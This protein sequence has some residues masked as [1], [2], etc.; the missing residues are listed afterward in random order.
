MFAQCPWSQT[1]V[2]VEKKIDLKTN[3]AKTLP[4]QFF[5]QVL[6]HDRNFNNLMPQK[7][8]HTKQN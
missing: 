1:Q 7:F 8:V 2:P 6:V 3:A 5:S 4:F